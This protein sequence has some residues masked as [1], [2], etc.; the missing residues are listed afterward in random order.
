MAKIYDNR[1][2]DWDDKDESGA[3]SQSSVS[4]YKSGKVQK[5]VVNDNSIVQEDYAGSQ[6]KKLLSSREVRETSKGNITTT[7]EDDTK[8]TQQSKTAKESYHSN[9]FKSEIKKE[10]IVTKTANRTESIIA[11]STTI[12]TNKLTETSPGKH[13]I[14]VTKNINIKSNLAKISAE[15]LDVKGASFGMSAKKHTEKAPFKHVKAGDVKYNVSEKLMMDADISKSSFKL[16]NYQTKQAEYKHPDDVADD[17]Y[18]IG[19]VIYSPKLSKLYFVPTNLVREVF[20]SQQKY[21][22]KSK[23]NSVYKYNYGK[24]Q[25]AN[26]FDTSPDLEQVLLSNRDYIHISFVRASMCMLDQSVVS[27]PNIVSLD[28]SKAKLDGNTSLI[29]WGAINSDLDSKV[30]GLG[31]KAGYKFANQDA[32]DD[33]VKYLQ[34]LSENNINRWLDIGKTYQA[35]LL[36]M[37]LLMAG[38]YNFKQ[39]SEK[40]A[41]LPY[42]PDVIAD[43]D[44]DNETAIAYKSYQHEIDED[45]GVFDLITTE[46]YVDSEILL[47]QTVKVAIK[48]NKY[49]LEGDNHSRYSGD[50]DNQIKDGLLLWSRTVSTKHDKKIE[51]LNLGRL[52]IKDLES[53]QLTKPYQL[54]YKDDKWLVY[55]DSK[56][57]LST[58]NH[59][60]DYPTGD[61]LIF[62][63]TVDEHYIL[64]KFY[65]YQEARH[66]F[67]LD[68]DIV[69]KDTKQKLSRRGCYE[70]LLDTYEQSSDEKMKSYLESLQEDGKT[71]SIQA[72]IEELEKASDELILAL[73]PDSVGKLLYLLNNLNEEDQKLI[74][75]NQDLAER[76]VKLALKLVATF[77]TRK[78]Y[79]VALQHYQPLTE[80]NQ[81]KAEDSVD[82][83]WHNDDMLFASSD[84]K[85]ARLI[86]GAYNKL[87]SEDMVLRL[88][89]DEDLFYKHEYLDFVPVEIAAIREADDIV[90][91]LKEEDQEDTNQPLTDLPDKD[92]S[93]LCELVYEKSALEYAFNDPL[94]KKVSLANI[95]YDVT[96]KYKNDKG[97]VIYPVRDDRGFNL[98]SDFKYALENYHVYYYNVLKKYKLITTSSKYVVATQSSFIGT[99]P[100]YFAIVVAHKG[101]KD[102]KGVYVVNRGTDKPWDY[103]ADLRMGSGK[104]IPSSNIIPHMLVGINFTQTI[105]DSYDL[106]SIGFTGHSLGGSISQIQTVRFFDYKERVSLAPTKCFEP[107]GARSEVDPSIGVKID[108]HYFTTT[109]DVWTSFKNWSNILS[110]GYLFDDWKSLEVKLIEKYQNNSKLINDNVTNFARQGDVIAEMSAQIGGEPIKLATNIDNNY[111]DYLPQQTKGL[112]AVP[113]ALFE[114]IERLN[115]HSIIWYRYNQYSPDGKLEKIGVNTNNVDKLKETGS[116]KDIS[117]FKEVF[118]DA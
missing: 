79:L 76:R 9:D 98:S 85:T 42:K 22:S 48:G 6:K 30:K 39:I 84:D 107:F 55:A 10:T 100:S 90:H 57:L 11:D 111:Y 65:Y 93:V 52:K 20:N 18:Y 46:E 118:K 78:G 34:S 21:L 83:L 114:P 1:P 94:M 62:E 102:N 71:V 8:L 72:V 14:T 117:N 103:W 89:K 31:Y 23:T 73:V 41:R 17:V 38:R 116:S 32:V 13:A 37:G 61:A 47:S 5:N 82:A 101:D 86:N 49:T 104:L 95:F 12:S 36:Y 29:N 77:N 44:Y 19:E 3:K 106:Q 26:R 51:K 113:Q 2:S 74:Q 68:E 50:K 25:V 108:D 59:D 109:T 53:K 56:Y 33:G 91:D 70:S 4:E 27:D 110:F 92:A 75:S 87:N 80:Y 88:R 28:F 69:A 60:L 16:Q 45:Y 7:Y 35:S 105:L 96:K 63:A 40:Q 115:V 64:E 99:A 81:V 24:R 15:K 54:D 97:Q 66:Q 67:E 112:V 58:H 43:I